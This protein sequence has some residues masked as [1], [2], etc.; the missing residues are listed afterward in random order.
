MGALAGRRFSNCANARQNAT[1]ATSKPRTTH[2]HPILSRVMHTKVQRIGRPRAPAQE[3]LAA[4]AD[5]GKTPSGG[6]RGPGVRLAYPNASV[7]SNQSGTCDSHVNRAVP[8]RGR[9]RAE[10]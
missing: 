3:A 8:R 5:Y 1:S 6:R 2:T 10:V 9:G 4:N 7:L